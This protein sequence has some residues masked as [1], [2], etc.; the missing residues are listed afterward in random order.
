[1]SSTSH[2]WSAAT[3][4]SA[5]ASAQHRPTEPITLPRKEPLVWRRSLL[6]RSGKSDEGD[7]IAQMSLLY[8]VAHSYDGN[9]RYLPDMG[10]YAI[11]N[12]NA[13]L[14]YCWASGG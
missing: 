7:S 14:D 12:C 6:L 9:V 11:T 10:M 5:Y 3:A 2:R 1:M 8:R 4:R 13:Q